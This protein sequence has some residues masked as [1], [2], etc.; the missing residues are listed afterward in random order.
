MEG[1]EENKESGNTGSARGA[2]EVDP[3]VRIAEAIE[4]LA[5]DPEVEIEAGPPLCPVCG[6]FDPEIVLPEQEGGRGL[7]SH[8][9]VNGAC[10]QC[11]GTIYIVIESYSVH[12]GRQTAMNEIIEREKAGFFNGG[13]R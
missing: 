7:M 11:G 6:A 3:L 1:R 4:K 5:S 13:I 8:V 9:I 12:K 10:G 2:E